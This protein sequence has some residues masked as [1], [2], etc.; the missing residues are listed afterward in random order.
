MTAP[1][2]RIA[3]LRR[4]LDRHNYNY[5]VLNAPE[6]SD[7]EFDMLM[8]ELEDLEKQYPDMADPLSPTQRVG[9]DISDK[10]EQVSHIYP[11]LS[12][13]NTYSIDEVDE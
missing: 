6:I 1:R 9:S 8:H 3:D 12:L 5:Y 10:F 13:A 4:Q 7:R 2:Q 11:M